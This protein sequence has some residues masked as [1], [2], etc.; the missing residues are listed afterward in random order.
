V[1]RLT[2]YLLNVLAVLSLLLCVATVWL[3]IRSYWVADSFFRERM[4]S[5]R[6]NGSSRFIHESWRV[7]SMRGGVSYCHGWTD[8]FVAYDMESS[9]RERWE[10]EMPRGFDLPK[11][12]GLRRWSLA[13][14]VVAQFPSDHVLE[15][16]SPGFDW[17]PH[18]IVRVPYW[19]PTFAFALLSAA[20]AISAMRRQRVQKLGLCAECGYDLRATPSRCP[21]CGARPKRSAEIST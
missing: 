2:R 20:L 10:H 4:E 14:I 18:R 6:V 9:Q 21:E 11:R 1:R 15:M 3:W 16:V 19:L 8:P 5:V 17:G 13:G 12:R 7:Q